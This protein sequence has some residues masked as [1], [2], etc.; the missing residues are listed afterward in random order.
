VWRRVALPEARKRIAA[1]DRSLRGLARAVGAEA[2]PE[3]AWRAL[4]PSGN[5]FANLNTIQ[6]WVV[7][8][9]RA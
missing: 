3:S 4:D 6:D 8:R 1:G 9:E 5:A 7:A 2:F